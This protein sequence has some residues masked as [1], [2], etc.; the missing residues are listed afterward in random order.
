MGVCVALTT[1][2]R[3]DFSAA[4]ENDASVFVGFDGGNASVFVD[5][6]PGFRGR[7]G[8]PDDVP[9][10]VELRLIGHAEAAYRV[11]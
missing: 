7:L 5:E 6:A 3:F 4:D 9:F 2:P 11:G 10:G 1:A 8:Q